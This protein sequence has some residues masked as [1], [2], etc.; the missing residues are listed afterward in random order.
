MSEL[1]YAF[2]NHLETYQRLG[3]PFRFYYKKGLTE[4]VYYI[5]EVKV[6]RFTG[7]SY[8]N[9]GRKIWGSFKY[10][11]MDIIS[12]PIQCF[13]CMTCQTNTDMHMGTGGCLNINDLQ[14]N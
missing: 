12:K 14:V 4:R 3:M 13:G 8:S 10:E 6:D 11:L 7:Y 1:F 9:D 2:I 5:H